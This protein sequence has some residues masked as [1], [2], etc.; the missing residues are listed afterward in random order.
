MAIGLF[1][2]FGFLPDMG[3]HFSV[4][5][6]LKQLQDEQFHLLFGF[7]SLI[8]IFFFLFFPPPFFIYFHMFFVFFLHFAFHEISDQNCI[9]H[10]NFG[11]RWATAGL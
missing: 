4:S 5:K 2:L 11:L 9:L 7:I 1:S 8:S 10:S 6:N 3:L